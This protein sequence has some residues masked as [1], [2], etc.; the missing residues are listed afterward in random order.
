[1]AGKCPQVEPEERFVAVRFPEYVLEFLEKE[2]E[3]SGATV[4]D[5]VIRIVADYVRSEKGNCG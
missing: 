4:S 3:E 5:V 1:M 2:S